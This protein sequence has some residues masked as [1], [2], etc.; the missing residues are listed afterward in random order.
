MNLNNTEKSDETKDNDK[1]GNS[2]AIRSTMLTIPSDR[3]N[4]VVVTKIP[5]KSIALPSHHS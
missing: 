3:G 4:G 2:S 1:N 5:R